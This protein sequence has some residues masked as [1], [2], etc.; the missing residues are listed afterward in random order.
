[1][2]PPVLVLNVLAAIVILLLQ[3]TGVLDGWG[4]AAESVVY[5]GPVAYVVLVLWLAFVGD[6]GANRLDRWF[7]V[8]V[9]PTMHLSW[10]AGFIVGLLRGARGTVDTS[11]T[12][13]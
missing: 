4:G 7:F 13:I 12:E 6:R 2:V 11:R 9:L 5:L 8:V 3:V 1:F 10:G